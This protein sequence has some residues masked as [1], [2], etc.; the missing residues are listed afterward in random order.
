MDKRRVVII[1][2]YYP[3]DG[4]NRAR[5]MFER[6][7]FLSAA[8]HTVLVIAPQ[9]EH[10]SEGQFSR[11]NVTVKRV[12]PIGYRR[13]ASMRY[14]DYKTSVPVLF[15]PLMPLLGYIRWVIPVIRTLRAEGGLQ[16]AV[17]YTP[18]NPVVLHLIGRLVRHSFSGWVA[19][20]RDPITNYDSSKRGVWGV[21][22][23]LIERLVVTSADFIALRKGIETTVS[24]LKARYPNYATKFVELPDYGVDLA[25]FTAK[26]FGEQSNSGDNYRGIYAGNYYVGDTPE[27]LLEALE[28]ANGGAATMSVDFYGDWSDEWALKQGAEYKGTVQ[29]WDLIRDYLCADFVVLFVPT[30]QKTEERWIPSKFSELLAAQKPIL[31]IGS[32]RTMPAKIVAAN[33]LGVVSENNVGALK[34]ALEELRNFI[35]KSKFNSSY[36][37]QIK[38]EISNING[39]TAIERLLSK[40]A[41]TL[42]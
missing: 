25:D 6:A 28:H 19:E 4:G 38:D 2:D 5:R 3:P 27:A 17:L 29:Y 7:R 18:N 35:K 24:E 12:P 42:R 31:V 40:S 13:W 33:H 39:E 14:E 26:Q 8:G 22:D 41:K 9:R 30:T 10:A 37:S 34:R 16:G 15:R 23:H 32:S 21:F 11:E 1:T 36:F 20:F